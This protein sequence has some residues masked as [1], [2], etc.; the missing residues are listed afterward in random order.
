[1]DGQIQHFQY[2]GRCGFT[3]NFAI[4]PDDFA[5]SSSMC[6]VN[7]FWNLNMIAALALQVRLFQPG[8]AARAA[9][10]HSSR[11]AMGFWPTFGKPR[12][13]TLSQPCV[14]QTWSSDSHSP[15]HPTLTNNTHG[16]AHTHIQ[17]D[18][19]THSMTHTHTHSH[20]ADKAKA[21]ADKKAAEE[22]AAKEKADAEAKAAAEKKV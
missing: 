22:K 5:T 14:G 1:M 7:K 3:F 9:W 21:A 13:P 15:N 11:S 12:H 2:F 10:T 20:S 16:L 19:R 4:D 17:Y 18:T 8:R 6:V